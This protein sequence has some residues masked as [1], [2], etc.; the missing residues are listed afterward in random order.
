MKKILSFL[1]TVSIILCGFSFCE[2]NSKTYADETQIEKDAEILYLKIQAFL[3]LTEDYSPADFDRACVDYILK[4]SRTFMTLDKEDFETQTKSDLRLY[5]GFPKK[6]FADNFKSGKNYIGGGLRGKGIYTTTSLS[7]A[8]HYTDGT[9][10]VIMLS[11]NKD[12]KIMEMSYLTEVLLKMQDLHKDEFTFNESDL[13]YDSM[14]DWI[15]DQI[16]ISLKD[17][18]QKFLNGD[19]T[20]EEIKSVLMGI[21]ESEKF[22]TL[23]KTRKRYYKNK[24]AAMFYNFGLLAKLLGYDALHSTDFLGTFANEKEEEY[25][26][27]NAGVLKVCK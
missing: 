3:F 22:K 1:M 15:E 14:Q 7:C 27:L 23:S 6:E 25:L 20:E 16:K 2:I 11:L 12:A 13:I 24:K 17:D 5:R 10:E 19:L 21:K 9:G 26:V 8:N 4:S 18:Y